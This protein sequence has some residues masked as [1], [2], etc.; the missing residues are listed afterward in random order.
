MFA[1]Q[2]LAVTIEQPSLAVVELV[3]RER[4]G[5]SNKNLGQPLE[6]Q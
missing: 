4:M 6:G 5:H 1:E 2:I 3:F